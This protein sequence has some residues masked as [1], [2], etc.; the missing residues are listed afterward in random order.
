MTLQY[1]TLDNLVVA[2]V[3][4]ETLNQP[5]LEVAI[6][7]LRQGWIYEILT[8]GASDFTKI[9]SPLNTVGQTFV[10]D[11]SLVLPNSSAIK[12]VNSINVV[13][14][15]PYTISALNSTDFTTLGAAENTVGIQF[16][17]TSNGV[18]GK[19]ARIH[20]LL[21]TRDRLSVSK[22]YII[23]DAGTMNFKALGS[24]SNEIGQRFQANSVA[25]SAIGDGVVVAEEETSVGNFI[26]NHNYV[27]TSLGNTNFTA[28]GASENAIGIEFIANSVGIHGTAEETFIPGDFVTGQTYKIKNTGLTDFTSIGA[29]DNNVGTSFIAT[30]TGAA[31]TLRLPTIASNLF[32]ANTKNLTVGMGVSFKSNILDSD[33]VAGSMYFIANENFSPA[34][35]N[36]VNDYN[37]PNSGPNA[38]TTGDLINLQA[39]FTSTRTT[40]NQGAKIITNDAP[41]V[42]EVQIDYTSYYERIASALEQLVDLAKNDGI[43]V[44]KPYDWVSALTLIKNYQDNGV[45]LEELK[46]LVDSLP[47]F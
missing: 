6:T 21:T 46:S 31:G 37:L 43:R 38:I 41:G 33:V 7:E 34:H 14:D 23:T 16:T 30:G 27:I 40:P 26:K 9:G 10:F 13:K 28:I 17:A 39:D 19:A 1:E 32:V 44:S 36:L 29:A 42:V 18:D 24:S 11:G 12:T 15:H 8:L 25:P 47:K 45:N 3:V 2:G 4:T 35:F 22:W 20:N 5:G